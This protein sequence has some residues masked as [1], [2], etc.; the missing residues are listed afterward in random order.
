[1]RRWNGWLA[2]AGEDGLARVPGTRTLPAQLRWAAR[3]EGVTHLDDLLLR[4]A[5]LGLVLP[6]G[7]VHLL[8]T[9]RAIVQKELGWS[10]EKWA[11]EE[12]AYRAL[13]RAAHAVPE[14]GNGD[15]VRLPGGMPSE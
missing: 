2:A 11:A 13:W 10:D 14:V 6:E 8:P 9:V 1:M 3:A 12:A 7:G 15:A 4:R 5:C